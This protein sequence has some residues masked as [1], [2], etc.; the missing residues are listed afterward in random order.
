MSE[1]GPQVSEPKKGH[2]GATQKFAG[3]HLPT[4]YCYTTLPLLIA[5]APP[6]SSFYRLHQVIA[7][8]QIDGVGAL[9][10]GLAGTVSLAAS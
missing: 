9:A 7:P 1:P 3:D 6:S 4:G 8:T 10:A 5:F 2:G